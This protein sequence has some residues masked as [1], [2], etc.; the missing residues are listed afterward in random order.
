MIVSSVGEKARAGM[1]AWIERLRR[2]RVGQCPDR[3][4]WGEGL[5]WPCL[6]S[7]GRGQ[8]GPVRLGRE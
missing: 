6:M 3:E 7:G 1:L 8:E 2:V 4:S 5:E